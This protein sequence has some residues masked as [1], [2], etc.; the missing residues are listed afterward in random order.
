MW[1]K[2]YNVYYVEIDLPGHITEL[3]VAYRVVVEEDA[4]MV[5]ACIWASVKRGSRG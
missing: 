1:D 4:R 3:I 5:R 2:R